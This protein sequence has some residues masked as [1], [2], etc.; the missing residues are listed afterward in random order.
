M[1][2]VKYFN[3]EATFIVTTHEYRVITSI[4]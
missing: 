2:V 4:C 3:D 1:R